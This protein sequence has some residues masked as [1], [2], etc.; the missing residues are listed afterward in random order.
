ML[1]YVLNLTYPRHGNLVENPFCRQKFL[2]QITENC[3]GAELEKRFV[4]FHI[5]FKMNPRI[6]LSHTTTSVELMTIV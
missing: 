4:H 6:I 3:S 5:K 1:E 2:Y